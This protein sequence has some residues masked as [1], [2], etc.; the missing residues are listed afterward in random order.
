MLNRKLHCA[1]PSRQ[2][3]QLAALATILAAITITLLLPAAHSAHAG[4][5]TQILP[6]LTLC[7]SFGLLALAMRRSRNPRQKRH[8]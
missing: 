3:R 7:L 4:P 8:P 1:P 5:L 2:V 6:W